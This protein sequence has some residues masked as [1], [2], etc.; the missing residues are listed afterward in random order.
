MGF[1]TWRPPSPVNRW[2][3]CASL[4]GTPEHRPRALALVNGRDAAASYPLKEGDQLK[5]V[6][7][8]GEKGQGPDGEVPFL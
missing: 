5:L 2:A 6:R 8:A 1:T 4:E 7:L 3:R